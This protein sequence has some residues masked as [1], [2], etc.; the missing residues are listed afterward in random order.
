MLSYAQKAGAE[1]IDATDVNFNS[2]Q[3][4]GA[5]IEPK[6]IAQIME[7][8]ENQ[9]SRPIEGNQGVYV[10]MVTAK[11]TLEV[12]PEQIAQEKIQLTGLNI[13][14]VNYQLL[15]ALEKKNEIVD[16]RYKFY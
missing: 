16:E 3:L 14:R 1:V 12:T 13:N 11:H 5:G 4:P 9:L 7:M 10:V 6:V 8:P 2:I 15:P